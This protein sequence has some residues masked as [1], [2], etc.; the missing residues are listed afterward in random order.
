MYES[1]NVHLT[2]P[3][4][5]LQKFNHETCWTLNY[6]AG[7]ID[8]IV[9]RP[10]CISFIIIYQVHP[11]KDMAKSHKDPLFRESSCGWNAFL[12][13]GCVLLLST[14]I[15]CTVCSLQNW[16]GW[17]GSTACT[18][19][20]E[21]QSSWI[22][23]VDQLRWRTRHY[24]MTYGM[25]GSCWPTKTSKILRFL[26]SCGWLPETDCGYRIQ[27]VCASLRVLGLDMSRC[28]LVRSRA[29]IAEIFRPSDPATPWSDAV[30]Q[31]L[32]PSHRL[33]FSSA[34]KA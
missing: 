28:T 27:I 33:S 2:A 16:Q 1:K 7:T 9:V 21:L 34:D 26:M 17:L 6:S 19:P 13:L 25:T 15:F 5:C 23:Q 8:G 11:K 10:Y 24:R 32:D 30:V 14:K 12:G 4:L 20:V 31:L 29:P 22:L 18:Q 3:C